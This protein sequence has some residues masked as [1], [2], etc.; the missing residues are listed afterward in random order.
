MISFIRSFI[1]DIANILKT[2]TFMPKKNM[3]FNYTRK[4]KT[5][6]EAIK[7]IV[8]TTTMLKNPFFLWILCFI[9]LEAWIQSQPC[10][11]NRIE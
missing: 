1:L 11:Y 7:K 2:I 10:W 3:S 6:F 9:L 4:E 8:T 5:S